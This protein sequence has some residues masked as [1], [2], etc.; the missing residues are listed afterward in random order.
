MLVEE[1][2]GGLLCSVEPHGG[3][4]AE[5]VRDGREECA[6]RVSEGRRRVFKHVRLEYFL[7]NK[8]RFELNVI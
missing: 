3:A 7:E 5:V 4:E 2:P 8:L 6:I 1:A